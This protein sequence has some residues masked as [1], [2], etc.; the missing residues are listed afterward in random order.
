MSTK[1]TIFF[2]KPK[3]KDYFLMGH[4]GVSCRYVAAMKNA[5]DC[6][7]ASPQIGLPI[8]LFIA[9]SKSTFNLR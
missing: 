3:T 9:D 1:K 6:A 8:R 4:V 7:L 5:N 2:F